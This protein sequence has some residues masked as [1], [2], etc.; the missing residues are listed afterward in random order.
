VFEDGREWTHVCTLCGMRKRAGR[1]EVFSS[2]DFFY[3]VEACATHLVK[4]I[5]GR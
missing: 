2:S 5:H 4:R 3:G 1:I